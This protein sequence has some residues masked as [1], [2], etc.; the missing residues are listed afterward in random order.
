MNPFNV[1]S[2]TR[3]P[4]SEQYE[5]ILESI[6]KCSDYDLDIRLKRTKLLNYKGELI[7]SDFYIKII[8]NEFINRRK[9]KLKKLNA[10]V[11]EN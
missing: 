6:K 4:T 10:K 9:L 2:K 7:Y 1:A 5:D 8:N 3:I 11:Q